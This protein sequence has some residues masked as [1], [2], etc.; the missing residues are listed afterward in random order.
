MKKFLLF[1]LAVVISFFLTNTKDS[2][3]SKNNEI[4]LKG[5]WIDNSDISEVRGKV[6][7]VKRINPRLPDFRFVIVGDSDVGWVDSLKIFQADD[8][9]LKQVIELDDEF[10]VSPLPRNQ[11]YFFVEDYNNDG[12]KDI[13]ILECWGG[14]GGEF[15]IVW[16]Y[17]PKIKLFE[18]DEFYC[19][20]PNAV[21]DFKK[22]TLET[23]DHNGDGDNTY[24][25][26]KFFNKTYNLMLEV[27]DWTDEGAEHGKYFV[28]D[29]KKRVDG[30]IKLISS[31]RNSESFEDIYELLEENY[32]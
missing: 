18:T 15:Y 22:R 20:L 5:N 24:Q 4:V 25:L 12:Y 7:F 3:L 10:T 29:I 19:N 28:R 11:E 31:E 30:K 27:K 1:I 17:N 23:Y 21:F 9:T 26:Y 8:T 14:S 16:I 2:V 32:K 6:E 13:R